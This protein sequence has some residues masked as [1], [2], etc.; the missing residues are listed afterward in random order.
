[1]WRHRCVIRARCSCDAMCAGMQTIHCGAGPDGLLPRTGAGTEFTF[2]CLIE[3]E[4]VAR[5]LQL[6]GPLRQRCEANSWRRRSTAEPGS[7][8][9]AAFANRG[10]FRSIADH[11]SHHRNRTKSHQSTAQ[12]LTALTPASVSEPHSSRN[13]GHTV[14]RPSNIEPSQFSSRATV[15]AHR[16]SRTRR[17]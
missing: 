12:R 4:R 2:L 9:G 7:V 8:E 6:S 17:L 11:S 16:Y 10:F 14:S 15:I 3:I 13:G 5:A 1:M